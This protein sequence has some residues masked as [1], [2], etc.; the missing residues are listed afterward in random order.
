DEH[1]GDAFFTELEHSGAGQAFLERYRDFAQANRHRG[2]EERDIY[3]PR[4]LEEPAMDYRA[5]QALLSGDEPPDPE[6]NQRRINARREEVLVEV[7]ANVRRS[8]LGFA[9]AEAIKLIVDWLLK[10]L[11]VRDDER[12]YIDR[13]TYAAKRAFLE[14]NRRLT[15]RGLVDSDRDIYF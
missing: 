4:R 10:F 7:L 6:A 13:S 3:F 1:E 14:I 12:Y 11:I 2:Q 5:W 8:P 9:K 15:V